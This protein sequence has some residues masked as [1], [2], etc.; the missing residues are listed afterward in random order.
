V[1]PGSG[2]YPDPSSCSHYYT[3]DNGNAYHFVSS[4]FVIL[5]CPS[6]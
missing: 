4:I 1:C 6:L 2:N 3:C 5:S